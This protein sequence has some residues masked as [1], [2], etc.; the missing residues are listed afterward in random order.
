MQSEIRRLCWASLVI[1]AM[2]GAQAGDNPIMVS[3]AIATRAGRLPV[4]GAIVSVIGGYG[5]A[6]TDATGR[7]TLPVPRAAVHR[8]RIQV[9]VEAH[10]PLATLVDVTL[11]AA[12]VRSEIGDA[13]MS[14]T[15][16]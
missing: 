6:T 14:P 12:R 8:G 4:P 3:G 9:K 5:H 11:D 2:R 10:G 7:F 1:P 16:C 13:A 15:L